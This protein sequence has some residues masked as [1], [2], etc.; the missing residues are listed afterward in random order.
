MLDLRV[1]GWASAVAT[2]LCLAIPCRAQTPQTD[3]ANLHRY[4]EQNAAL[5]APTAKENRVVFMGNSITEAWARSFATQF[6]GKPYIGRGISG[7][8]TPQM[9]IRFR[10]DVVALKP[11]S[12]SSSAARTTSPATRDPRRSR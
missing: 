8:T 5:A 4:A 12:S 3:W 11:K 6:P 9:L 10:P 1:R 2:A 7:Q